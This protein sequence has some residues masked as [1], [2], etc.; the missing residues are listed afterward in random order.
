[1]KTKTNKK[2]FTIVE[3]VIVIAVIGILSA[4]L[5]PT[6]ANLTTQAQSTALQSDLKGVYSTYASNAADGYFEYTSK[7]EK[8]SK[9]VEAKVALKLVAQD[10]AYIVA[11]NDLNGLSDSALNET[12]TL[13]GYVC[14]TDGKWVYQEPGKSYKKTADLTTNDIGLVST[15]VTFSTF[16][17][18]TV[19]Y[20]VD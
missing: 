8:N 6:F 20:I 17:N 18:Y 19:F 2:G 14:G 9:D 12:K 1:M 10:K 15:N 13:K 5:I 16:N 4:I 11:Q 7:D 3:L